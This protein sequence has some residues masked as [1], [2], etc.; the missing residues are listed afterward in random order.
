MSTTV[1]KCKEAQDN[2]RNV[3]DNDKTEL[4][5]IDVVVFFFKNTFPIDV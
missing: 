2:P 5:H 1:C 4:T 3:T